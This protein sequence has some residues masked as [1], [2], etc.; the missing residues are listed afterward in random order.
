VTHDD[1]ECPKK[2]EPAPRLLPQLLLEGRACRVEVALE[3][4]VLLA[5]PVR[6]AE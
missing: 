5:E 1:P 4:L 3:D 6:I 2:E